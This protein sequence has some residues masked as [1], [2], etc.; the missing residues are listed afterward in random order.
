MNSQK[1]NLHLSMEAKRERHSVI[2][3]NTRFADYFFRAG[4]KK[5]TDLNKILVKTVIDQDIIT[6]LNQTKTEV[7]RHPI[8][9]RYE[10]EII[11]RFP[12]NEEN[13]AFPTHTP[14]FCFPNEVCLVSKT[15]G[16]PAE[17]FHSFVPL[18]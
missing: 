11:Y 7:K 15:V 16:N 17:T 18:F 10:P 3:A 9:N 8:S 6:D 12:Q 5:D 14:L 1:T 4:I 13:D 2:E